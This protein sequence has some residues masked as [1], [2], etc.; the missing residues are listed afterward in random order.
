M[1]TVL[2]QGY[3]GLPISIFAAEAGYIVS[4]FDIDPEKILKLQNG[5]SS[6]PEVTSERLLRL[7][8]DGRI[9]FSSDIRE[10]S[11]SSIFIIAVPTP[12]DSNHNPDLTFLESACKLIAQVIKPGS[13]IINESTSYIGT[14]RDFIKPM[15][16]NISN[17]DGLDYAVAPERIDPGNLIWNL[18]NTTR[19]IGGLNQNSI[20]RAKTFYESFCDTT[21]VVSAPEVAE[22]AKLFENTFRQ[23]NIALANEFSELAFKFGFSAHESIVAASTKPFGF[24]P[25]FPSIGTGGH[26]IPVD[27]SYLVF[28]GETMG[29]STSIIKL[30][31]SINRSMPKNTVERIKAFLGGDLL[32]K[33][34]QVAGITYK[35]NI[36][37]LRESPAI[38]LINMLE[39]NGAKVKWSDP[40]VR[41]FNDQE[42]APL[43]PN[44]DLGLIVTPHSKFDFSVWKNAGTKVLDLSPNA[45][46]FGWLKFF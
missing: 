35:P 2:G 31:N 15:V 9:K 39:K 44:I 40:Y 29:A 14:L 11:D 42:S 30:A 32:N 24:M 22:A 7:Q 43:D 45:N 4:G 46:D 36:A 28:S 41:F 18:K 5:I 23:V 20:D 10:Q 6:S 3:V 37:D 8:Q 16:E 26:C 38:S 13:L 25:F 1:I 19:I 33:Q 17:L 21:V 27:P 34:L 12:L